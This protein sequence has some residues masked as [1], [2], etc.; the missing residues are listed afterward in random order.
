MSIRWR[1]GVLSV[2]LVLLGFGTRLATG[3][4]YSSS[5]WFVTGLLAV[6]IYPQLLE[7]FF[8]RAVDV[9][10]NSIIGF[11]L[12]IIANKSFVKLGWNIFAIGIIISIV[13]SLIALFFGAERHESYLAHLGRVARILTKPLSALTIYSIVFWLAL[14]EFYS[15]IKNQ[16]WILGSTWAIL[17]IISRVNWQNA[18]STLKGAPAFA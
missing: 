9:L 17:V 1:L 3:E 15:G 12:F 8:P 16:V 11:F 4:V 13:I 18:W 7:P 5:L 2:Q 14:L 6:A 10:A